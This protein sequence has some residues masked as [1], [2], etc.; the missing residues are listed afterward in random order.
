MQQLITRALLEL[1]IVFTNSTSNV[2]LNLFVFPESL[3]GD[4][5][6]NV[7]FTIRVLLMEL[8]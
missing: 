8:N 4:Q 5:T 2:N 6:L 1:Y 7:K 3:K